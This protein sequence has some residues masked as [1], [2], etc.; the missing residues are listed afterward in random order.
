MMN[1]IIHK[2]ITTITCVSYEVHRV[3]SGQGLDIA[4]GQHVIGFS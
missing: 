1:F 2:V 4:E 3:F